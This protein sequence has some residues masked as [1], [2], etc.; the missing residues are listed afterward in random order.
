MEELERKLHD[1][2]IPMEDEH[3][4]DNKESSSR[5]MG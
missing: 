1:D 3:G 5:S 4:S 2:G